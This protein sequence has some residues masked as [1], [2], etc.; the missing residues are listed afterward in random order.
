MRARPAPG[1]PRTPAPVPA[2]PRPHQQH[3]HGHHGRGS[4]GHGAV[5]EDDV[6]LA[7]LLGQ[8][9]VVELRREGEGSLIAWL[10]ERRAGAGGAAHLG[11]PRVQVGLDEDLAQAD[12]LAH[13]RE[14]LLHGLPCA[15]DGHAC[16]LG[17][18]RGHVC[19]S[20]ELP[21]LQQGLAVLALVPREGEQAPPSSSSA[22]G[23]TSGATGFS[24]DARPEMG[25]PCTCG[26]KG[27]SMTS[28]PLPVEPLPFIRCPLRRLH[29]D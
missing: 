15:Q 3:T 28:H 25:Q 14:R 9:Q 26:E 21:R 1:E 6:V 27:T 19:F 12:V 22:Q 8:A 5:H 13:G 20:G 11:L 4:G 7:D 16:D 23:Q 18:G 24:Q 29:S 10:P 17:K 2:A